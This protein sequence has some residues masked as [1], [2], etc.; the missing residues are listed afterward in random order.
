MER[1]LFISNTNYLLALTPTCAPITILAVVGSLKTKKNSIGDATS[2]LGNK[3]DGSK[4]SLSEDNR[5]FHYAL[6][7]F[8]SAN[9]SVHVC[10][11]LTYGDMY[12]YDIL[13]K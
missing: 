8:G 9:G 10:G 2:F 11:P 13:L 6:R 3:G 12:N 1:K 7:Y 4:L 5:Q